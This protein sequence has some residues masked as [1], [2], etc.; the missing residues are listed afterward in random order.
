MTSRMVRMCFVSHKNWESSFP[1]RK[2]HE[3]PG[4]VSLTG[5]THCQTKLLA[6]RARTRAR[7][8]FPCVCITKYNQ[9]LLVPTFVLVTGHKL[10]VSDVFT[11]Q[12]QIPAMPAARMQHRPL[13]LDGP[14]LQRSVQIRKKQCHGR[15]L[16]PSIC[17]RGIRG[18]RHNFRR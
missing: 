17:A 18:A 16:E 15:C 13:L 11:L 10:P 6:A 8:T 2:W 3:Q 7:S 1:P 9:Y 12:K 4:Q 14:L 5:V